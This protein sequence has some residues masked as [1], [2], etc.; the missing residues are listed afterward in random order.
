MPTS[1][2]AAQSIAT[3]QDLEGLRAEG[4]VRDST[5]DQRDG[6]GPD[7]QR[8]NIQRFAETYGLLLGTRW[9]TEFVSGRG[10]AKRDAFRQ[11]LED[12]QMDKY[13]VLLV[14]HTSRFGRN[15]AECI[16]HKEELLRMGKLMVFVSQ[17]IISG[18]DR[19]FINERINETLDEAYSRNLSRYIA[20]GLAEKAAKGV[21]NG[22]PPLGYRSEK[23]DNGKQ[24]RKVP[25]PK[26]IPVLLELLGSYT[27][28]RY[29]YVALADHL[30]ALGHR[31]RNGEPFTKGSVEHIVNN[32]FYEGK[33]VYHGGRVDEEVRVGEHDV[34][35]EVKELWLQCQTVKDE[36][37]IR[38]S[39]R[40][41]T[42]QRAY[43]FTQVAVCVDCGSRYAGQA[44]HR[45]S[46]K[47][48]L[49]LY[50]KRPFCDLEPHSVRV[51]RLA[52]QFQERIL[53]FISLDSQWESLVV[54]N[55]S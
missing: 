40:P 50:H 41:R 51:D 53:A 19:D 9:Y 25:D 1:S 22:V 6:F 15:Q 54:Q 5:L 35:S 33:A 38:P 10:V 36:R 43:P 48:V 8:H 32:R 27:S 39:G 11:F 2:L 49:R 46:G 7:I 31:T 45:P 3:F 37:R 18:S 52:S 28:G 30:N 42:E 20:A 29:S 17:G 4:Y 16:R 24:E 47:V 44:S 21:A 23:L 55:P 26:T 12:A 13:H 14:D 34:P